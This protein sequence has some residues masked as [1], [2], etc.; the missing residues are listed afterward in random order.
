VPVRPGEYPEFQSQVWAEPDVA[1]ATELLIS[2]V[3]DPALRRSVGERARTYMKR[4]FSDRV[5][6]ARYV[7]RLRRL[8]IRPS[9]RRLRTPGWP[10]A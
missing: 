8:M 7:R 6:G 10:A 1:H 3:D 9:R 5:L 4:N 2:L